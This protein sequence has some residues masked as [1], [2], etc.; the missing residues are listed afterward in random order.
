MAHMIEVSA[1]FGGV[2][3]Q[4]AVAAAVALDIGLNLSSSEARDASGSYSNYPTEI[5]P[6]GFTFWIW[7]PI[8][9]GSMVFA[10]F[11][12]LP[13]Q[14][15]DERLDAIAVP[16]VAASLANAFS[17]L[18]P[19]GPGVLLAVVTL[20]ALAAACIVMRRRP[21][22]RP[23]HLWLVDA[24]ILLFFGW[25]TVATIVGIAQW[26]VSLGW[27]GSPMSA[28]AWSAA[29]IAVATVLGV[30]TVQR[31]VEIVYA[32]AL[33]WAFCGVAA[34]RPHAWPIVTA[35]FIGV[36]ALLGRSVVVVIRNRATRCQTMLA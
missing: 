6:A 35:V 1:R 33:V 5:T 8:F 12:A 27:D 20:S 28:E 30:L 16:F 34:T 32:A 7:A 29:M 26:M 19:I 25:I 2:A 17:P 9:L 4:F 23:A 22:D 3:R 13:A 36:L 18:V 21:A 24:P 10:V 31:T 11:Q 15:D 14:R